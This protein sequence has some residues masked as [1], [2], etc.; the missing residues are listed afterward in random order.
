MKFSSLE[1]PLVTIPLNGRFSK[2]SLIEDSFLFYVIFQ[3]FVC[4]SF[5]C[6]N[7]ALC[8]TLFGFLLISFCSYQRF[9]P[10]FREASNHLPDWFFRFCSFTSFTAFQLLPGIPSSFVTLV[11]FNSSIYLSTFSS[12]GL[13]FILFLWYLA[14]LN[15]S[16]ELPSEFLKCFKFL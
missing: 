1:Y 10:I 13:L 11:I 4:P 9:S 15:F 8:S 3:S 6:I 12:T 2:S 16:S 7:L 14:P 5:G